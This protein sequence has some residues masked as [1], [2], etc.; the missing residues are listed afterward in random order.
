MYIITDIPAVVLSES[1]SYFVVVVFVF[2]FVC[3]C[4]VFSI[5]LQK[6]FTDH[7]FDSF[8]LNNVGSHDEAP[9]L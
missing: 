6:I 1:M 9:F 3:V 8:L 4:G 5:A 2:F 7:T